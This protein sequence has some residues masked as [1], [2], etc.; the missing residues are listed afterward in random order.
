MLEIEG[1][2]VADALRRVAGNQDLYTRL[3]K[4][5]TASQKEV[6]QEIRAALH[7][8]RHEDAVRLAH[9]TKGVAGNL[10]AQALAGSAAGLELALKEN[11]G[12]EI[13]LEL[14]E[15]QLAEAIE[16]VSLTLGQQ[17][18]LSQAKTLE[19]SAAAKP[20]V[21]SAALLHELQR[22]LETR[23]AD[24]QDFLVRET[25]GLRASLT[26]MSYDRLAMLVNVYDFDEAMQLL[27]PFLSKFP[28]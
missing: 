7:E 26:S 3:L 21:D 22:Y 10:G 5:F 17:Q 14:F 1:F 8:Q 13:A 4:Q 9:N 15:T 23:D 20:A 12:V 2:N 11:N 24:V 16:A 27:K 19:A 6:A 18:A 28:H 25:Q